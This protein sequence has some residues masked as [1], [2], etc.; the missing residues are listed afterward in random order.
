M[1]PLT[2]DPESAPADAAR[3]QQDKLKHDDIDSEWLDAMVKRLFNELDRQMKQVEESRTGQ[4]DATGRTANART[5]ASLQN[6]MEKLS[7][8]E[9]E[10]DARRKIKNVTKDADA[11]KELERKLDR[12]AAA[13]R[14]KKSR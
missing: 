8:M 12:I 9:A 2:P 10:R 14:T 1:P 5:L 6:T 13:G 4:T 7:R 3:K 11:R